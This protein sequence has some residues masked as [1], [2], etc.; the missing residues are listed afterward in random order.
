MAVFNKQLVKVELEKYCKKYCRF[1]FTGVCILSYTCFDT[2]SGETSELSGSLTVVV[3]ET[4]RSE[5][6]IV[7][8]VGLLLPVLTEL[9]ELSSLTIFDDATSA[10]VET[11]IVRRL[12]SLSVAYGLPEIAASKRLISTLRLVS[13]TGTYLRRD[14]DVDKKNILNHKKNCDKEGEFKGFG[15]SL[16]LRDY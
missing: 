14:T 5:T 9:A 13:V 1:S 15:Q 12:T 6:A 10:G 2:R 11:C 7:C 8:R 4:I 3:V 16:S